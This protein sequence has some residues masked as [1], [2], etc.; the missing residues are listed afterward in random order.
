MSA[1]PLLKVDQIGKRFGG[2]TVLDQVSFEVH[3]GERLG[4]IGPNGSGKSTTVNC[5]S[6]VL[7]QDTGSI[8]FNGKCLD[9]LKPHQRTYAGL[10]RSFQIPRPFGRL[11]VLKNIRIP[12]M[13]AAQQRLGRHLTERELDDL[14]HE[15]LLQ[16]GLDVKSNEAAAS[17]TQIDLRKLEL[18]R[19]I[20]ARP[21]LLIADESMAGLATSES[22]E[23]LELLFKLNSQGIAIIMIEHIMRTVSAFSQRLVVLA[24]GKKIADGATQDVLRDPTVERIY[25]GV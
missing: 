17:L 18:A 5:L 14:S 9:G 10:A 22:D 12:L 7:Q 24:T 23:I 15:A 25:L 19:A 6:G 1:Q 8:H 21:K 2:F 4:L 13:F 16:V 20:A 11:S 3:P